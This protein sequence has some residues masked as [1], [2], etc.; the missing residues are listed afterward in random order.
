[1]KRVSMGAIEGCTQ[2]SQRADVDVG[3]VHSQMACVP[4]RCPALGLAWGT[5]MRLIAGPQ[6]AYSPGEGEQHTKHCEGTYAGIP[7]QGPC[8]GR[9]GG[10]GGT[11]LAELNCCLAVW[12]EAS[13]LQAELVLPQESQTRLGK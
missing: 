4:P 7:D 5:D 2:L 6:G 10:W 8:L 9:Q 3:H 11:L 12:P 1:M 13:L